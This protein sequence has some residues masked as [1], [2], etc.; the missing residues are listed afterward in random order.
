MNNH[1]VKTRLALFQ[2]IAIAT[3]VTLAN[4]ASGAQN[5]LSKAFLR[6]YG[7]NRFR[8]LA[9]ELEAGRCHL[10]ISEGK[11]ILHDKPKLYK[12]YKYDIYG[13]IAR[14]YEKL[15]Y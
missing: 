8:Y 7:P 6:K 11:K 3:A 2:A 14:A 15:G 5:G 13:T 10:V 9:R 12:A 4:F 1:P